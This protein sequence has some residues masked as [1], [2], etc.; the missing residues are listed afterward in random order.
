[1]V[2]VAEEGLHRIRA[3]A[4]EGVGERQRSLALV[5]EEAEAHQRSRASEVVVEGEH[6]K[7][8]A[9]EE[10]EAVVRQKILVW[11][12]EGESLCS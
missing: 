3:L 9:L 4:V 7:S 8:Q 6:L 2:E 11:A 1:V 12:A 10:V 5:G